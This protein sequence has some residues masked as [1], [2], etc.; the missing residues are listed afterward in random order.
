MDDNGFGQTD[1]NAFT[2]TNHYGVSFVAYFR[3][4]HDLMDGISI[5]LVLLLAKLKYSLLALLG[6]LDYG[7][8]TYFI[9][10]EIKNMHLPS[11]GS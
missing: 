9:K 6:L 1:Y 11:N 5:S 3:I 4:L 7:Y 2:I 8:P 10:I